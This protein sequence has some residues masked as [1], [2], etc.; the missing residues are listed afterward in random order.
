MDQLF[1]ELE[2]GARKITCILKFKTSLELYIET[3]TRKES[4]LEI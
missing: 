4:G 2:V 1:Q 3:I